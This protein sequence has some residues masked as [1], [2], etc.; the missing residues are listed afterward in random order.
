MDRIT[1]V[2]HSRRPLLTGTEWLECLAK[3]CALQMSDLLSHFVQGTAHQCQS[4]DEMSVAIT[5]HNLAGDG[6]DAQTHL[7]TDELFDLGRNGG[8]R[9]Y[10]ARDLTNRDL[11][12]GIGKALL[13][14]PELIYPRRKLEAKCDRFGVDAVGAS[15]HQCILMLYSDLSNGIDQLGESCS[16]HMP[17]IFDLCGKSCIN[18]IGRGQ[19][20]MDKAS[21]RSKLFLDGAQEGDEI[22]ICLLLNLF[23]ALLVVGCQANLFEGIRGD[24]AFACPGFARE[25][26]HL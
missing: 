4:R 1:L 10:S 17:G 19:A 15:D 8:M 7:C 24:H 12:Q 26:L 22:V 5:L 18:H 11:F 2:W 9:A 13:V 14:A 23:H 20:K 25:Q 3:F 21:L 16:Q 6:F